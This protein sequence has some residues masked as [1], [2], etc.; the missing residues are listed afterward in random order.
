[1]EEM[2]DYGERTTRNCAFIGQSDD[3][4]DGGGDGDTDHGRTGPVGAQQHQGEGK[5]YFRGLEVL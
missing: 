4:D 3:D 2:D 5:R 1:M